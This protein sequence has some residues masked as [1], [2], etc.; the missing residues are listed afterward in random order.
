MKQS[1][2]KRRKHHGDGFENTKYDDEEHSDLLV[3]TVEY[4][5][6]YLYQEQ[7]IPTFVDNVSFCEKKQNRRRREHSGGQFSGVSR[8][9]EIPLLPSMRIMRQ[10]RRSNG[11]GRV[12]ERET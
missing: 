3:L 6:F 1:Q 9:A 12:T 11:G 10:G 4:D 5:L 7:P 2:T 8:R